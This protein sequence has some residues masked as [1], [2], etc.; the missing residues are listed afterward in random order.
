M[1]GVGFVA[2]VDSVEAEA[3]LPF[4]SASEAAVAASANELEVVGTAGVVDVD[5]VEGGAG[6]RVVGLKVASVGGDAEPKYASCVE[7]VCLLSS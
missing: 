1:P 2:S 3:A 6:L 4:V 5:P 7:E